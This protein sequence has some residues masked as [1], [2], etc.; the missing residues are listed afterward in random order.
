MRIAIY[1]TGGVGGFVGAKLALVGE[2]VTFVARGPHLDAIRSNGLRLD[3]AANQYLI[4]P[5]KATN[6][7]AAVGTVDAVILGVK[8]WQVSE[9]AEAIRPM[10]GPQTF[11]LTLQNGIDAPTQV[12]TAL[13]WEHVVAGRC[14]IV[15][16]IVAPGHIR[17]LLD[18][19]NVEFGE[20]DN[21]PSKRTAQ[22]QDLFLRA[23]F[24][25]VLASNIQMALWDKLMLVVSW[26]S[27]GAA[28]RAPVGGIRAVPEAKMLWQAAIH[29]IAAVAIAHQVPLPDERIAAALAFIDNGPA[30]ATTSLQRDL[31]AGRPSELEAWTGAVVR[32]GRE[33]NVP[34]PVHD[35]I[36]ASLLPTELRARGKI[37]FAS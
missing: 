37:E 5:A 19:I 4:K 23:G 35:M 17:S 21:R 9:A 29:E 30:A 1:G 6:D 32:L 10:I 7:T 36:Y 24:A 31:A 26:G 28:T 33:V 14:A 3:A 27:V 2:D 16:Y 12:A 8:T 22:L 15:S 25:S 18:G 11:V 13:G 20:W 34:V